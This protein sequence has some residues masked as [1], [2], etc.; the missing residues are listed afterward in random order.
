MTVDQYTLTLDKE[1]WE[2]ITSAVYIEIVSKI[3]HVHS[4][5]IGDIKPSYVKDL[6][7]AKAMIER[8]LRS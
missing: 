6:L 2:A 4:G 1:V 5:R 8:M 3:P 7:Y